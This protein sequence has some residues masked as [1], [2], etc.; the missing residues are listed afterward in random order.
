MVSR[1]GTGFWIASLA[2]GAAFVAWALI[3]ELDVVSNAVG[4][5]SPASRVKAIQHLEGGIVAEILVEEGATVSRDQPLIRL[6]PVRARA[7]MRE[8]SQRLIGLRLD[9]A[10]LTAE[11]KGDASPDFSSEVELIAP[12]TVAAA[13]ALFESHKKRLDQDRRVQE[14][15]V[16]QR[17]AEVVEVRQ[18]LQANRRSL[19]LIGS[20]VSIS[21][22]LLGRD[23]TNRMAHLDHLRQQ[24]TLRT[25]IEIDQAAQPRVEAALVE[26]RERLA[27]ISDVAREQARRDLAQARQ[28]YEELMQRENRYRNVEER[29]ILRAPVDGIVKTLAVATEGGVIQPGQVVAEIVPIADRLVIEARLPLQDI[30]YVHPG[31]FVRVMLNTPDAAAFGHLDGEVTRVS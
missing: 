11:V 12:D 21:E 24:Q 23:L 13:R 2:L 15:V 5:V 30:G 22:N 7:E 20:Q 9:L 19:D 14:A 4:E 6:D 29:T 27:A 16:E 28:S 1:T 18:R 17:R 25:Q 31:Q 10:R 3:C 8:L 26:A